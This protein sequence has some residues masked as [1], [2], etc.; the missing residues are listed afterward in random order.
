MP[1]RQTLLAASPE[2]QEALEKI[3]NSA[4]IVHRIHLGSHF[5]Q[6]YRVQASEKFDYFVHIIPEDKLAGEMDRFNLSLWLHERG[7]PTPQPVRAPSL[8]Q[9]TKAIWSNC[10]VTAF[11]YYPHRLLEPKLSDMDS[12]ASAIFEIHQQLPMHLEIEKWR[13]NT[14]SRLKLLDETRLHLS[15]GREMAGPEP[16]KIRAIANRTDL[17]FHRSDLTAGYLHGDMN[18]SNAFCV[19][20]QVMILDFEDVH[21]S[22][23]PVEFELG[24]IL[25]RFIFLQ[26]VTS[27]EKLALATAFL[28]TYGELSGRS[29]NSVKWKNLIQSLHLRSLCVL[30]AIAQEGNKIPAAEWDKFIYLFEEAERQSE[31]LS[32]VLP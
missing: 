29:L 17:D 19:D 32:E 16:D 14:K 13:S 9:S 15:M 11:V 6:M 7:V 21:H 2:E 3:F 18:Y 1:P 28:K 30:T 20:Q 23:L 12:L 5:F 25:E 24:L 22:Y 26:P 27:S 8:I 4:L 10:Y 31:L